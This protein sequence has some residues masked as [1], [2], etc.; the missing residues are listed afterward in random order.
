MNKEK[1]NE[2]KICT[3]ECV[4]FRIGECMTLRDDGKCDKPEWYEL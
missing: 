2:E 1:T 3:E 4:H